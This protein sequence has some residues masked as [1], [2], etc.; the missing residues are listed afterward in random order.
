MAHGWMGLQLIAEKSGFPGIC[1]CEDDSVFYEEH[2][3]SN[4]SIGS[5]SLVGASILTLD[6][7]N[8]PQST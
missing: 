7:L 8:W 6:H 4:T 5:R 1:S 2:L 3:M